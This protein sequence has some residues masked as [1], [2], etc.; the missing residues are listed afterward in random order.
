MTFRYGDPREFDVIASHADC[1][2][3]NYR[4]GALDLCE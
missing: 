4:Q 3:F 1:V 2:L